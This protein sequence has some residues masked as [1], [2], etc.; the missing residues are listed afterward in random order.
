MEKNKYEE[1][2]AK[3]DKALSKD[4]LNADL[5]YVYSLIF[6]DT[7]YNEYNID[8]SYAYILKAQTDYALTDAKT[9][10]KQLKQLELDSLLLLEQRLRND[11]LAFQR[12]ASIHSVQAYQQFLDQ[13]TD[14]PQTEQAIRNRNQLAYQSASQLDTYEAYKDFMETYPDAEE[15]ELAKERYNTLVFREKTR[16]G[17]LQSYIDFLEAFPDSPFRAQAEKQIL[18]ISTAANEYGSYESFIRRYP[19]SPHMPLAVNLLF[20]LYCDRFSADAFF[21]KYPGLPLQDSLKS[22]YQLSQKMLAPV[23][24]EQH[25]GLMDSQGKMMIATQYG[26]VPSRY[27][28]N[29]VEAPVVHMAQFTDTVEHH[30]ILTK[31]GENV[32]DYEISSTSAEKNTKMEERYVYT[33]GAGVLLT[34]TSQD[35]FTLL[36][37]SGERLL[38]NAEMANHLDTAS[39][40]PFWENE[41]QIKE[42]PAYQFIRFQVDGLWG[43]A[44]FTGRVLLEPE[45]EEIDA[46]ED[47]I[48]LRKNGKI[49]V[50]KREKVAAVADQRPLELSFLYEDV[51]LLDGQHLIAY[52]DEYESVIDRNLDIAVP[53]DRHNVIRKIDASGQD[54]PQWL[55]REDR[56]EAYVEND[57]LLN[58]KVSVYYLYDKDDDRNKSTTF[59]NASFS[60]N[61]LAMNNNEGFHFFNLQQNNASQVYDSVK[62]LGENFALLFKYFEEGKDSVT[63]LFPNDRRLALASPENINFLL[64]RPASIQTE[65]EYILIAPRRGPK[66]VWNQYGQRV[67]MD[68]FDDIKV[69]GPGLFVIEKNRRKGLLDSLGNELLPIRYESISNYMDSLLAVFQNRKFGAYDYA[70]KSLIRPQYDAALQVYGP[71]V[72]HPEDSSYSSLYIAREDGSY[73]LINDQEHKLSSFEFDQIRYWNDTAALVRKDGEWAIYRVKRQTPY[74]DEQDYILYDEIEELELLEKTPEESIFRIYKDGGYGIISNQNGEL[75]TPTYDD[76]RLFGSIADPNSIFLAEKYVPEAELYVVI[77]LNTSGDII[78]RQ[79]LTSEQYDKVFCDD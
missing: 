77:H 65:R 76:I 41:R 55:L 48:L 49:A 46:L 54:K 1:A 45:Y 75:L 36:L 29:G 5:F 28:C 69:Y 34:R 22:A 63:V 78:K 25:Y 47:F 38:P 37:E 9:R 40:L 73:G 19:Q 39:L 7:A 33:L 32:Y 35:Q 17:D 21:Q 66:E 44:T 6:S 62:L 64:L 68:N 12:A 30:Y 59:R 61:W 8:S 58:R 15:H 16:S 18:E 56:V 79:A 27:L 67:L 70:T 53:L 14:A 42:L 23:F 60:D 57:S 3:L 13:H 43:L 26:I 20:H 50:T 71:M 2:R 11:S 31:A 4:S 51:A 72:F 74:D 52:T 24:E 10:G